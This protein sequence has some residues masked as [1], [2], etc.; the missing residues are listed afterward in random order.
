M[1]YVLPWCI[2]FLGFTLGPY[3]ASLYLSFS[4]WALMGPIKFVGRSLS[5]HGPYQGL[6]VYPYDVRSLGFGH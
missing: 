1:P 3:L 2:G 4:E 5:T 6:R